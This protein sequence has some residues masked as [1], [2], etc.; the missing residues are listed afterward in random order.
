LWKSFQLSKDGKWGGKNED[1]ETW[2]GLVRMLMD[3]EIDISTGGLS[4]IKERNEVVDFSIPL[5]E[6]KTTLITPKTTGQATR[7]WVY[8]EIFPPETWSVCA[9]MLFGIALGFLIINNS[10]ENLLH[11]SDDPEAFSLFNSVALSMLLLMQL[12]YGVVIRSLSAKI[13][14]LISGLS[15]YLIFTYY[16]SDLTA[17]M[18][19]GPP[20]V[21]IGSFQDVL[22]S[23]YKV[24]VL[25][26]TSNHIYLKTAKPDSAM[27]K[28]FK[29]RMEGNPEAFAKTPKESLE[30]PLTRPNTLLFDSVMVVIVDSRYE[31][32]KITDGING[33][34]GWAF[35]KNSEFTEYF[36]FHLFK[37]EESGV[38]YKLNRDWTYLPTDVYWV[39]DAISLGY[40]NALFPYL[41]LLGG[42]IGGVVVH[43]WEQ[44]RYALFDWLWN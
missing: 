31:A 19:S 42:I 3:K 34:M 15:T 17:R 33:Q 23:G 1:G 22:N 41:I 44:I 4:Q 13:L 20:P 9:A 2:N 43:L 32:L 30:I 11:R 39:D 6:D 24:M 38:M 26:D 8:L 29:E 16:T 27:S 28:V 21:S 14:F 40:D 25:A 35:Q 18:T 10:G 37:L 36:N 7:I 12:D 5:A